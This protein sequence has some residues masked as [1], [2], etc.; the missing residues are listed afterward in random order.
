MNRPFFTQKGRGTSPS[1]P[2][3]IMISLQTTQ[4]K[5][6]HMYSITDL[7]DLKDSNVFVSEILIDGNV[8]TLVLEP[9][10]AT[11]FCPSCGFRMH[12][13]GIKA[14]TVSHPILQD[15]CRLVLRLKQRRWRTNPDCLYECNEEFR[16]VNKSRRITNATDMMITSVDLFLYALTVGAFDLPR[17]PL[18]TDVRVAKLNALICKK[19]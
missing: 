17:S 15:G 4:S 7:L 12:S 18:E 10:I 6:G 5:G 14:R 3:S 11:H 1:L 16:F 2:S 19:F 8:K 13:R 9:P